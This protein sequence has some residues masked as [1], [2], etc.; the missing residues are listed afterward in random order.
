MATRISDVIVPELFTGYAQQKTM[1]KTRIIQSGVLTRD[2]ALDNELKGGGKIFHSPSFNDL[3][4]S[5]ENTSNDNP[6]DLST[7]NKIGTL[8][9]SQVRLSR[10]NSWSSMDLTAA[11]AGADPMTAIGALVGG[12]WGRRLQ[13]A[14]VSTWRGVFASNDQTVVAGGTGDGDAYSGDMTHSQL[15]F[16]AD[17]TTPKFVDGVTNFHKFSAINTNLTMGD[18]I[19]ELGTMFVHSIIY[20][21]MQRQNLVTTVPLADGVTSIKVFQ[22]YRVIVDNSVP[23]NNGVY[24]TWFFG[25]NVSRLGMGSPLVPTEVE[26]TAAAGAGGGQETLHNRLEL[27][28]HPVGFAW[29]NASVAAGGPTNALLTTGSNWK[30]AFT[31]REQVR[32]ARL[33]TKE[34]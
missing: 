33:V 8:M 2:A 18:S 14:F 5:E 13:V 17:G 15:E 3:D 11:L 34:H 16:E 28:I 21:S 25:R 30:R 26:R 20:G 6:T 12:Y 22:G 7:P 31:E 32:A 1:E 29:V 4:N 27:I 10:N 9:E 24:E 19:D 23:H